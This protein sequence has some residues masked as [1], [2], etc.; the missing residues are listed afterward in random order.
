[1]QWV[2]RAAA[3]APGKIEPRD[4][5]EEVGQRTP[6]MDAESRSV[7]AQG[8]EMAAGELDDHFFDGSYCPAFFVA[9]R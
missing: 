1:M 2:W 9:V 8:I 7:D 6:A 4:L 5:L 3:I